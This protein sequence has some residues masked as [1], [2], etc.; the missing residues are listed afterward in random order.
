MLAA[1]ALLAETSPVRVDLAAVGRVLFL[2]VI[3]ELV[4]Q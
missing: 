4:E 2:A 1:A 3:M